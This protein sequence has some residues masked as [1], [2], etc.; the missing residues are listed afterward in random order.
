MRICHADLRAERAAR[1]WT[2]LPPPASVR[3]RPAV[4]SA[5]ST[6]D[7]SED[8]RAAGGGRRAEARAI[9]A[10]LRDVAHPPLAPPPGDAVFVYVAR[11]LKK[12]PP[13]G[14]VT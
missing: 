13:S 8:E 5:A 10:R 9:R 6:A 12:S 3:E 4:A 14:T 2:A 7:T 11:R 1:G